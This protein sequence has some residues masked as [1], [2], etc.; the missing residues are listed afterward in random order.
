M[1]FSHFFVSRPIFASVLSIIMVLIGAIAYFNLPVSQYPDIAPPSIAVTASY[2]GASAETIADTV[3]APL[4]QEINGVENM[5]YMNSFSTSDGQLSLT[6]TFKIGTNLDDALVFV[7]NRI[8]QALPRLPE[9]VRRIGVV[10]AKSSSDLM[11][12]V[13]VLSP[14]DSF[15]QLYISNYAL[16]RL[17]DSINRLP[18]VGQVV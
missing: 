6:V 1:K 7:Q 10:T 16:L 11:M 12:V 2:P 8:N 5:L 18:G 13:H 9:E 15:D 14:D 17:K 3:A 4:E